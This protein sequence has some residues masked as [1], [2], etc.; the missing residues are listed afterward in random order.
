ML[1]FLRAQEVGIKPRTDYRY[2][3]AVTATATFELRG[4]GRGAVMS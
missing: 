3:Q 2:F 1:V 4:G